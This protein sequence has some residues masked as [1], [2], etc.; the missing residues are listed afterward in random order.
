MPRHAEVCLTDRPRPR[1]ACSAP[2]A[3]FGHACGPHWALWEIGRGL[4]AGAAVM[5]LGFSS[6]S[7][8]SKAATRGVRP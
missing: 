4:K 2:D 7:E 5:D 8:G 6:K 3:A 1:S